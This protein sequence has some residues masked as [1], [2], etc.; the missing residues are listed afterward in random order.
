ME[1][2]DQ[3]KGQV[4]Y[5]FIIGK[6]KGMSDVIVVADERCIGMPININWCEEREHFDYDVAMWC[7]K[8]Y[9]KI[10]PDYLEPI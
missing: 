8:R 5:G 2:N 4:T 10:A 7:R 6:P 3:R 9:E 1:I